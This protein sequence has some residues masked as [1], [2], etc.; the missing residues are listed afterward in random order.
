MTPRERL[1][2]KIAALQAKTAAAGCTEAEAMAAAAVA[3]RLMAEHAFDQAD[4]EMT[5]ATAPDSSTRTTNRTTWRDKVSGA[6]ALVTNCAWLIRTNDG[7]VLFVGR[8]PGPDIAAYLRDVCFRAVERALREFKETPFYQRRRKLSTRRQ[9]AADF[10]EGMVLRLTVRLL[11]LFRSVRDDD[12]RAAAKQALAKRAGTTVSITMK[13][14]KERYSAAGGAG[15]RA[16]ADV[17]LHH[18][19]AGTAA[20]KQIGSG[21]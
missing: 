1:R 19:V 3:A 18:G 17:G 14:R 6:I 13:E 21:S 4:I 8:E 10:V 7:D 12:A 9:A 5:E 2:A 20:P 11:E 15:W 16:G